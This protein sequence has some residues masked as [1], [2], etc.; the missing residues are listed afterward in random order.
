MTTL[1]YNELRELMEQGVI[2]NSHPERIQGA[3][4]DLTLGNV[5]WIESAARCDMPVDL[6]NIP[7]RYPKFDPIHISNIGSYGMEPGQFILGVTR[8]AINM[9]NDMKGSYC[10]NSSL[11]RAGLDNAFAGFI[12]PGYQGTITVE[13]KNVLQY[14]TL[15]IRPGMRVG[16]ISFERLSS[17]VPEFASYRNRGSYNGTQGE[18]TCR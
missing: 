10:L 13:L 15:V 14:H 3:S 12:D 7:R 9:P 18:P 6:S 4:I 1:S 17:P 8:E 16:Q 11:G 2:E 5:I